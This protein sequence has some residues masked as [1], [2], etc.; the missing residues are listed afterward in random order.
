MISATS[1]WPSA[2]LV[3]ARVS[4]F[5]A[6]A[7]VEDGTSILAVPGVNDAAEVNLAA[8]GDPAQHHIVQL[9]KMVSS[10]SPFWASVGRSGDGEATW[11]TSASSQ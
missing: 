6:P 2:A 3:V 10:T 7:A 1:P 5:V 11:L 4:L 9:Q 8:Q